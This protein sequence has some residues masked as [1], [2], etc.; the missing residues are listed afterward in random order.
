MDQEEPRP[1]RINVERIFKEG[2]QEHTLCWVEL[3]P[4]KHIFVLGYYNPDDFGWLIPYKNCHNKI[5]NRK[6]LN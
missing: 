1:F 3:R 6:K 2:E 5:A 4:L